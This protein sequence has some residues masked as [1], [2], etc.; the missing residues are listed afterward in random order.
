MYDDKIEKPKEVKERKAF[1]ADW[2]SIAV[3]L[4]ILFFFL[5]L[6]I[7]VVTKINKGK[8]EKKYTTNLESIRTAAYTY[9]KDEANRPEKESEEIVLTVEDMIDANLLQPL[10]ISRKITC[11][12]SESYAT[13]TK[14]TDTSYN[15]N[16]NLKCGEET[17]NGSYSLNYKSLKK[18]KEQEEVT[19]EKETTTEKEQ[20][21]ETTSGTLYQLKR[22][23]VDTSSYK[24]PD[25]FSL[26]GKKCYSNV[27]LMKVNATVIYQTIP[28]KN[29]K[30]TYHQ[31]Q[32][33]YDEK[34]PTLNTQKTT[35][36][37]PSGYAKEN[38]T[39]VKKTNALTKIKTNYYCPENYSL[40]D[41]KCVSIKTVSAASAT[42]NCSQGTLINN[43]CQ[44]KETP[45]ITCT[46]GVYDANKKMCYT[47]V[48][49]SKSYSSWQKVG[50]IKSKSKKTN[51][52]TA[53]YTYKGKKNGYY[54]YSK[55]TRKV[56]GYY[57]KTGIYDN[58]KCK[59]YNNSYLKKYCTNGTLDTNSNTCI[60]YTN[61]TLKQASTKTC[62]STYTKNGNACIKKINATA[63]KTT[64]YYCPSTYTLVGNICKK[65]ASPII[66]K[67]QTT[68][69]CP[70]GYEKVNNTCRKK[71][72]TQGYYTCEDEN[73]TLQNDRCITKS[74][75]IFK[76][77][78]CPSGY[79]LSGNVCYK[80]TDSQTIN[81]T[82][83]KGKVISEETIWSATKTL[84]GWT[85]TGKTKTI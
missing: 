40:Q 42:Y 3:K 58:K 15:L 44:I 27:E 84:E 37:C 67:G 35:I 33:L 81:A 22:T 12:S 50:N 8:M 73:A 14:K 39:C 34:T 18:D 59:I 66:N 41:N 23:I 16:V 4:L 55:E 26:I 78:K 63:K 76:K 83:I 79:E 68:I 17:K 72:Q 43:T 85:F 38:Q 30:A 28:G 25:G 69:T 56:Q 61:A 7:Y 75:T 82:E 21:N 53:R 31:G 24:C 19:K 45:K 51:T 74:Q 46:K 6:L 13:I 71:I 48:N 49:A 52:T 29:T 65:T 20:N 80:Y 62:P 1:K 47:T 60:S 10:S 54:I 77:Y 57:C 32:T 70:N 36:T 64:E 2:A 9:F 5:F 11:D